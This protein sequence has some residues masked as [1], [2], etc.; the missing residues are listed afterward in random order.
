MSPFIIGL[1]PRM[2]L[3]TPWLG[4]GDHQLGLSTEHLQQLGQQWPS[5]N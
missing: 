3:E 1:L 2:V 5:V 4:S